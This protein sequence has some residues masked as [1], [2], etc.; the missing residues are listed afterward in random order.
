MRQTTATGGDQLGTSAT[1]C[2]QVSGHPLAVSDDGVEVGKDPVV[3][4][5]DDIAAARAR[6]EE[7]PVDVTPWQW[8][9]CDDRSIEAEGVDDGPG[10]LR[11]SRSVHGPMVAPEHGWTQRR[12]TQHRWTPDQGAD[13]AVG[14]GSRAQAVV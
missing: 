6:E 9:G 8:C 14:D 5:L 3:Q 7:I 2:C 4:T 11:S 10:Y 13:G 12:W 1:A